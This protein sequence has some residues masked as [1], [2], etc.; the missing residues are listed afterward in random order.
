MAAPL[1]AKEGD[2]DAQ[3]SPAWSSSR[4]PEG[5]P[6]VESALVAPLAPEA[7]LSGAAG[8]VP[9]AQEPPSSQAMVTMSPPPLLLHCYLQI[10]QPPLTFWSALFLR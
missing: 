2:R 7:L 5:H 4:G 3:A 9:K 6:R 8:E 1:P 10:L